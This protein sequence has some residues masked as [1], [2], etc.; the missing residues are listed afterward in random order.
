LVRVHSVF[1]AALNFSPPDGGL[2]TLLGAEADDSPRSVRLVSAEDFSSLGLAAGDSGVVTLDEIVL[3]PSA[4]RGRLRVDCSTARRLAA[5]PA[6]PLRL[7]DER[8]RAGVAKLEAL[9]E[10]AATDLRIAPLM[11]AASPSGAMG[12]RLTE[13][14]LDLGFGARAGRLDAMR[15]AAARLVGLGQGLTPAGD[16]FLCGFLAAGHCLAVAGLADTQLLAS[17]AEAVGELLGQTTDISASFLS[18]AIAGRVSRRL[19]NLAEACSGA[20]GRD[21]DS[22]LLSLAAIGHSSGLDAATGFFYGAAVWSDDARRPMISGADR[23]APAT[24]RR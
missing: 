19:A 4:G 2:L 6:P 17:F 3:E 8:W 20:P 23:S 13:A 15:D 7:D 5:Q 24:T 9:Q 16:D 18:D 12:K 21:L 10:R 11:T 1:P 22:A 14:V